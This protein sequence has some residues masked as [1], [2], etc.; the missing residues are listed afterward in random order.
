MNKVSSE[1]AIKNARSS[2]EME[3]LL[4]DA[5]MENICARILDGKYSLK[6][7]LNEYKNKIKNNQ[8]TENK[9]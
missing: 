6:E 5:E 8:K 9:M 3:G 2:V 1:R 4:V 7:Y